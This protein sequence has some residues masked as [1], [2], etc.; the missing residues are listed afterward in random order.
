MKTMAEHQAHPIHYRAPAKTAAGAAREALHVCA[1]CGG[2]HVHP[3]DW[4]EESHERW[5][6]ALRCPDCEQAFEGVFG[7]LAVERLD[8]EL[9]RASAALLRDY[10]DLVRANM[11]EEADLLARAL[12]FDLIGPEDFGSR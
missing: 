1:T 7:R 6:I 10:T 9:D 5:R 3:V 12:E 4:T 11:S 2:G 8:D